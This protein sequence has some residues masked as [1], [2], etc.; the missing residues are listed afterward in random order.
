MIYQLASFKL[1]CLL[2]SSDSSFLY[3]HGAC[4]CLLYLVG[5]GRTLVSLSLRCKSTRTAQRCINFEGAAAISF[6]YIYITMHHRT[7]YIASHINA[8]TSMLF[9]VQCL[10]YSWFQKKKT[11]QQIREREG[12]MV[13][14]Y[15]HA[16]LRF[17]YSGFQKKKT[18]QQAQGGQSRQLYT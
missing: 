14:M 4:L 3:G 13:V 7:S 15:L 5:Q 18:W 10:L 16:I 11:L 12:S 17:T 8:R 2:L 9:C 6:L 1:Y